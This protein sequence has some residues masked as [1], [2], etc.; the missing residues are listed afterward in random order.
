[1]YNDTLF[2][3]KKCDQL[4]FLKGKKIENLIVKQKIPQSMTLRAFLVDNAILS[5]LQ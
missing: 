1:M 4:Q 3:T 5:L 2:H